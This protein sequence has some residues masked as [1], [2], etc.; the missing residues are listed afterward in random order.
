MAIMTDF[1]HCTFKVLEKKILK[2]DEEE[3]KLPSGDNLISTHEIHFN[4][5]HYAPSGSNPSGAN[6]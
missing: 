4:S 6:E 2:S 3:E 1:K 5:I